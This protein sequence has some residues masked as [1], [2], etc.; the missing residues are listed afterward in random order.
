[1][2]IL[3]KYAHRISCKLDGFQTCKKIFEGL[4][5]CLLVSSISFIW[6]NRTY[7]DWQMGNKRNY[8]NGVT[9]LISTP[10]SR[11][12]II[13]DGQSRQSNWVSTLIEDTS[14]TD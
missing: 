10:G 14:G 8:A 1:M 3:L 13:E 7:A 5:I 12:F 4:I 9:A 2:S 11:P 6:V